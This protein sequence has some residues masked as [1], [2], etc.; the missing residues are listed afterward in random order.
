MRK[1]LVLALAT[2]AAAAAAIASAATATRVAPSLSVAARQPVAIRGVHFLPRERVVVTATADDTQTA[3]V[4]ANASGSFLVSFPGMVLDRCTGLRV[5]AAGS[6]G[7]IAL[8]KLPLPACMP[9]KNP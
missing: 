1:I 8:L 2:V 7:S 6:R 9:A 5:R 3:R 4:R